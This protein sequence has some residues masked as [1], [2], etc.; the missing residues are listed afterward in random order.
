[1]HL[2][3][4]FGPLIGLSAA[5][6]AQA[7]A[8]SHFIEITDEQRALD[9]GIYPDQTLDRYVTGTLGVTRPFDRD[10]DG[11]DADDLLRMQ[12]HSEAGWRSQSVARVLAFDLDGDLQVT[13]AEL[14]RGYRGGPLDKRATIDATLAQFDKN[15]DGIISLHEAAA[16]TQDFRN[17]DQIRARALLRLDPDRDGKLT[18]DELRNLAGQH[19]AAVDTDRDGRISTQEAAPVQNRATVMRS[20]AGRM[21]KCSFPRPGATA[22]VVLVKASGH[23]TMSP[24][25][26]GNTDQVVTVS[27]L[28]IEPKGKP[29]YL[30]LFADDPVIWRLT[31]ATDRVEAVVLGTDEW[32]RN[33]QAGSPRHPVAGIVGV[34]ESKVTFADQNCLVTWHNDPVQVGIARYRIEQF[35]GRL[36]SVVLSESFHSNVHVPSG[37]AAPPIKGDLALP[38][39]Y[40]ATEWP[41][42]VRFNDGGLARFSAAQVVARA[43][44]IPYEVLPNQFGIA[45]IVGKG[46]AQRIDERTLRLLR[47]IP[48][49]PAGLGGAHAENFLLADG[50][51]LPPG[52]PVHSCVKPE[53][54]RNPAKPT[55]SCFPPPPPETVRTRKN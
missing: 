26:L 20:V 27:N 30:V 2:K 45:Q 25:A 52:D 14:D 21:P 7:H 13:S 1:M 35:T 29:L 48:N 12:R 50:V 37:T 15:S 10:G 36:P 47:P 6:G 39:G 28:S 44:P 46:A 16:I 53:S 23:K 33:K 19:F 24:V 31:G 17:D 22:Q 40:S 11:L 55:R 34:D 49:L 9:Q 54:P 41:K 32:A 18:Q 8:Q 43:N 3:L 51:P 5:I 42:A 38:A 4:I